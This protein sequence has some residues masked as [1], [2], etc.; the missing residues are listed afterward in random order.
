MSMFGGIGADFQREYHQFKPKDEP[1]DE[2]E[3]R[4]AL[5]EL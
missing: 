4:V 1:A 3:D 2:F 5:Y